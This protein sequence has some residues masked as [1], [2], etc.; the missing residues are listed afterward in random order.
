M[1]VEKLRSL[2]ND[3]Q[4]RTIL[5]F[6]TENEAILVDDP[7]SAQV[8]AAAYFQLG[9]YSAA[10]E[11]LRIH[12]ASLGN[13]ASFLSLY[14]ANCRRL[15]NLAQA[16]DLLK[17]ALLLEP[18][19]L[20]VRNNYANLLIDLNEFSEAN[21]IL[22]DILKV[23]PEYA[24]AK[25][26]LNRLRYYL[27]ESTT[28]SFVSTAWKPLD[29]LMLAFADDEVKKAGS[30]HFTKPASKSSEYLAS[31]LPEPDQVMLASEKLSLASHAIQEDNASF[32]L[33]LASQ[34]YTVLGA[35]SNVY[36]NVADAYIRLKKF[37][38]AEICF[39]HSLQMS[40]PSL[41]IFINLSTLSSM[42]GDLAL[43]R[44]YLDAAAAIDPDHPQLPQLRQQII[45]QDKNKTSI[46]IFSE[47]WDIPIVHK[48]SGK[49]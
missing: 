8:I 32:A 4:Y 29:P 26:N 24:D 6:V 31:K 19:S 37:Y 7:L 48:V 20:Y 28:D 40:G 1:S 35:Q 49:S 5:S 22:N 42:R 45:M 16:R 38:E 11:I 10:N 21:V 15:G 18:D 14:G 17:A 9:N 47:I 13:D 43:S 25:A 23:D 12:Q 34:A 41:P 39:L 30:T 44:Y 27:E 46:F 3:G 2:F 33:Q 36:L